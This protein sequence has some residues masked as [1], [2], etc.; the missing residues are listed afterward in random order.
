MHVSKL[1]NRQS[2]IDR[3][4]AIR[5][6]LL[7]VVVSAGLGFATIPTWGQEQSRAE[8]ALFR[9]AVNAQ[10]GN[11]FGLA[12]ELWAEF[13]SKFPKSGSLIKARHYQAV[14]LLQTREIAK[15]AGLFEKVIEQLPSSP[16]FALGQDAYLNLTWCKF[17]LAQQPKQDSTRLFN[18]A[19]AT[20]SK[21]IETYPKGKAV[22]QALFYR[23]E[24]LYLQGK[25]EDSLPSYQRIVRDF[26]KSN[27]RLNTLYA[28]GVALEE[29]KK[30][31][32]AAVIYGTYL[33][34]S[35]RD[36]LSTEVAMRKAESTLQYGAELKK[37]GKQ[38]EAMESIVA[39]EKELAAVAATPGFAQVDHALSRQALS[40]VHQDKVGEAAEVY[41]QLVTRFPSS[42]YAP[43]ATLS[44]ARLFYRA[45]R[46]SD[47]EMWFGAVLKL[48]AKNRAEAGHWLCQIHL[49][50]SKPKQAYELASQLLLQVPNGEF[51]VLLMM[52][53]ADAAFELPEHRSESRQLYLKIAN[54]HAEH[55]VAS[56]ALYY[57]CHSSLQQQEFDVAL[58]LTADFLKK[59][60]ADFYSP[61]VK[62]IRA[63]SLLKK[64]DHAGAVKLLQDLVE[65]HSDHVDMPVWTL[66]LGFS[67]YL[68]E[69][70]REATTTL[71]PLM[72]SLKNPSQIAE[73]RYVIGSSQY[74][75][76]EYQKAIAAL[77]QSV[78]ADPNWKQANQ[79]R[80]LIAESQ[81]KLNST[82]EAVKS[83][84][85][86]LSL[87][88]DAKTTSRVHYL[89]AETLYS[90]GNFDKAGEH[91]QAV[92]AR[93]T[94]ST[95]VPHAMYGLGWSELKNKHYQA[96][97]DSFSQLLSQHAQH[98]L[99][100]DAQMGRGLA[101][102]QMGAHQEAINDFNAVLKSS[103]GEKHNENA[104]Y[105]RALSEMALK[106]Y[107]AATMTLKQLLQNH[108]DS[109]NSEQ[110][111]Y[112]LAWTHKY[113]NDEA[114][115]GKTFADLAKKYP[116]GK[117]VYEASFHIAESHYRARQYA[118]ALP[119]YKKSLGEGTGEGTGRGVGRGVGKGT[120]EGTKEGDG[121]TGQGSPLFEKAAYKLGWSHFHLKQ[122]ADAEAAFEK[123]LT[124]FPNGD[125]KTDGTFMVAES[126]FRSNKFL[127][128][129]AAF[130]KVKSMLSAAGN[131]S[132]DVHLL[133]HLHG[134]QAANEVKEFKAAIEFV[135][136][137][138]PLFQGSPYEAEAWFEQ[139]RAQ[140]G[141][142]DHP[143]AMEAYEQ[144]AT[145][146][147]SKTG[148][149]ARCMMGEIH[150]AEKKFAE[151][152]KQYKRVLYGYG[153]E[154]ATDDVRTWQAFAGFEAARCNHVQISIESDEQKR[155][156]LIQQAKTLYTYVVE[157]H[158]TDKLAAEAKRQLARLNRL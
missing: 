142:G 105:E 94:V 59:Y 5:V 20:A 149:R 57:A 133:T 61:D 70:Y 22:D 143:A 85:N 67:L 130:K 9:E 119:Y 82:E 83:M 124:R 42:V 86:L 45:S 104:S 7:F 111:L 58:E 3:I 24:S 39:A 120:G 66:R 4:S 140:Q 18:E 72:A 147:Q 156:Q 41:T 115:A 80:L 152:I 148:A 64:E 98:T 2:C 71:E 55:D 88:P 99:S 32:S 73:G 19:I 12:A 8:N 157:D 132:E 51:A 131:V 13:E 46:F 27:L 118:E 93:S 36:K 69:K 127:E 141:V 117:H 17:T 16:E 49:K 60:P 145:L 63:E 116:Q 11:D 15:A 150:F 122:F 153:G 78:A 84:Q 38:Q 6:V 97:A 137:K 128:S 79:A 146:S 144:A 30:Y 96:A 33:K 75:L 110:Y 76:G 74:Q 121:G 26:P 81:L 106:K 37:Q 100:V 154:E 136:A 56:R 40:L 52:D 48:G 92:L 95:L 107:A 89:L 125:L 31:E 135:D 114:N 158:S 103:A 62:S 10:N 43:D 53:Q 139:G 109:D 113:Q 102:R 28:L 21:M 44:A 68:Q 126:L 134:G 112:D 87:K 91:Y 14:C 25:K 77:S 138:G 155:G 123:Q 50:N 101:R 1:N 108:A 47:A 54:D 65:N 151:A 29:L 23:A 90:N 34:E 129:L 35:P